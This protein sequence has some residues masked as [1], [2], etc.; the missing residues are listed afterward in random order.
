MSEPR[1]KRSRDVDDCPRGRRLAR[2]PTT[3]GGAVLLLAIVATPAR[4]QIGALVS[5]GPLAKA[6]ASLEGASN[7][8]KCHEPGRGV[9]AERCLACHR[10]VAERIQA[11]RGV[12]RGVTECATCHA[13]HAGRGGDLLHFSTAGFNH[14]AVTGF[15]LDGRHAGR[16]CAACHKTRSYLRLQ[17]ACA[18]CHAD[19]HKGRFGSDC[20]RCHPISVPFKQTTNFDHSVTRFPLTGAHKTVACS[21]CHVNDVFRALKFEL[22]TDCHKSPH[23]RPLGDSCASCHTAETWRTQKIDHS[24]TEYPLLGRHAAVPCASCH[25]K[26]AAAV[27][28]RFARCADCHTDP[29]KGLFKQDCGACHQVTGFAKAPFDHNTT[30]FPLTGRHVGLGCVQC[31][32]NA[33]SALKTSKAS[34]TAKTPAIDFRGL[35]TTCVSCHRDVHLGQLGSDCERCH[36][37]SSEQFAAVGFSHDRAVFPLLGLHRAVACAGCHKPE[38]AV[39]PSGTGTAV[40]FKGIAQ[41]C[42]ACHKDPHLGQVGTACEGCHSVETRYLPDRFSHARAKFPLD[43]RH[44]ELACEKCHRRETGVFPAGAGTAVRLTGLPMT[45]QGCHADPH[46]GQLGTRCE[47]CHTAATFRLIAYSHKPPAASLFTGR[48]LPLPCGACHKRE[49]GAYPSGR[50]VAVRYKGLGTECVA[51]HRDPHRGAFDTPCATC[52]SPESWRVTSRAFHQA[53]NFPLEGRHLTVPCASCHLNGVVKGTPTACYDCHWIRRQDD[54]YRTQLGGQCQDCHRP[55]SWTAVIWDHGAQTGMPLSAVHRALGCEGC[56]RNQRFVGT[57]PDC[58]SC[59]LADYQ[60]TTSPNHAAAGFPTDCDLC[61]KPSQSS[62][63]PASFNH[64]SI[65]PLVGVHA[66]Q[67]CAACHKG[68]V[69]AGTPRDCY[70]CHRTDYQN[71]KNP[72]HVAAGFPTTCENCHQPSAPTWTAAF[73]HNTVFPLVGVHAQQPCAACHKGNVFAGTPRD[74][75]GCHRTDYQN[76]KDPNHVGAGFPTTCEACHRA[77]D[78][79]WD[80]GAFNHAA[81]PITTGRHA[82]IACPVCHTNPTNYQV[83]SCLNGCHPQAT[84][85]GHHTGVAGYRYDSLACYACHPRGVGGRPAPLGPVASH[86]RASGVAMRATASHTLTLLPPVATGTRSGR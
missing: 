68:N 12:H 35:L 3:L 8:E 28:V 32:K 39:Y 64:G 37:T 24:K 50:A 30:K 56:H 23:R 40:R 9:T 33:A 1:R 36:P 55:I 60:R 4:A 86:P 62:W 70:G 43:G 54:R 75:Y 84:T 42:A 34:Q 61:H 15:A 69:L 58:V 46:A 47:G 14:A 66:Q 51:C 16:A 83:F 45:C 80:R 2:V 18:S 6:H 10:P 25:V 44:A 57:A 7:C 20:A 26:P 49:E 76:A 27:R 19:P 79:S 17:P 5:P 67:P 22:C 71:T 65:Y 29:H 31:H 77:T 13:E 81:F 85:N 21:K 72:N 73:N 78:P 41:A 52:H 11:G 59:H 38:A 63:E 48:H 53:S 74:C 82:G